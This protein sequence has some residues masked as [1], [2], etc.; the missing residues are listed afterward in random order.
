MGTWKY[1]DTDFTKLTYLKTQ[2]DIKIGM[3]TGHISRRAAG[4]WEVIQNL[5]NSLTEERRVSTSVLGLQAIDSGTMFERLATPHRTACKVTGPQSFGYSPSLYSAL[6]S[7]QVDLVHNHGAWMYPSFVSYLW[8]Q[9]YRKPVVIS[10]H[11]MLDPWAVR[12]GRWK[13]RLVSALF[14]ANHFKTA[15]CFHALCVEEALGIKQFGIRNP[16]GVIP[17]GVHL[18]GLKKT[19]T[20]DWITELSGGKN[21]LLYL[22]RLHPKKGLESLLK[23]LKSVKPN[24]KDWVLFIVGSSYSSYGLFL[25]TMSQELGLQGDVVFA[26]ARFDEEK[27]Q[28]YSAASGF[29]LPSFSEGLPVSVLEAWAY[30]LPCLITP[31]CHL[32]EGYR[33]G[34]AI[35]ISCEIENI[36]LGLRQFFEMSNHQ[37]EQMGMKG[38]EL[39]QEKYSWRRVS[40]QMLSLYEWVL[41]GDFPSEVEII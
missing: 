39:V 41:G 24:N 34:A 14:E 37:R 21:I 10:P 7:S 32:S 12:S 19:E 31:A 25:E 5:S 33:G 15:N 35:K 40:D 26:G 9:R 3:L 38:R 4:V 16:V 17:N 36:A 22:G 27:H 11:G 8:G 1:I 29:I 23:P 6:K 28:V 13:K 18:P 30:A 2:S 20:P